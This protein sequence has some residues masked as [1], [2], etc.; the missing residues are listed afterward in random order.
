M[1]ASQVNHRVFA[2]DIIAEILKTNWI[3]ERVEATEL[4]AAPA[5]PGAN[6]AAGG[7]ETALKLL[8]M[9]VARGADRAPT[10]R[11][12]ALGALSALASAARD[13]EDEQEAKGSP[14]PPLSRALLRPH[15]TAEPPSSPDR[16]TPSAADARASSTPSGTSAAAP[17]S[18]DLRALLRRRMGDERAVVRRA[19]AQAT[20][21]VAALHLAHRGE[22]EDDGAAEAWADESSALGALCADVSVATRKAAAAGLSQLRALL[23]GSSALRQLWVTNVLP[24]AHDGEVTVSSRCGDLVREAIVEPASAWDGG[25]GSVWTL[26]ATAHSPEAQKCLQ[27]ALWPLALR[28]PDKPLSDPS[29]FAGGTQ[30]HARVLSSL[31]RAALLGCGRDSDGEPLGDGVLEGAPPRAEVRQGAWVLFEAVLCPS[32]HAGSTTAA[33]LLLTSSSVPVEPAFVMACWR[34]LWSEYDSVL[35]RAAAAGSDAVAPEQ[36]AAWS[37]E[38]DAL[39]VDAQRMLRAMAHLAPAIAAADASA[40]AAELLSLLQAFA[41]TPATAA[42]M[43]RAL[44]ALCSAKAPSPEQATAICNSFA[45]SLLDQAQGLLEAYAF[46]PGAGGMDED[47]LVA[48][49]APLAHV[50]RAL[51][52]VGEVTL[53]G[54]SPDDNGL[55]SDGR[56]ILDVHVSTELVSLV[57]VLLAHT[58]PRRGGAAAAAAATADET[59]S[60]TAAAA[61]EGPGEP[62]PESVRAFALVALGKICLVDAGLAKECV[63]LLVREIDHV[64]RLE[65]GV[66]AGS[67]AVQSN[68]LLVLGDLC[69]RYTALVERHMPALA[70]CLQ[71]PHALLRRHSLLLLSQLLLQDYLKWRGLLLPR[72]LLA[73]ADEDPEVSQLARFLVTGPLTQKSP[74]LLNHAP[75]DL[76]FVLNGYE[77]HPKYRACLLQGS[78]GHGHAAVDFRGVGAADQARRLEVHRFVCGA[79]TDEQRIEATARLAHEVLKPAAQGDFPCAHADAG[80]TASALKSSTK[81]GRKPSDAACGFAV[82]R[83]ALATLTLPELR[84]GRGSGQGADAVTEEEMVAAAANGHAAA[85]AAQ[86]LEAAKGRL[87]SKVSLLQWR[88]APTDARRV[89]PT[90]VVLAA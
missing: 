82:L 15:F 42:A 61:E 76:L 12:R 43:L 36:S 14:A 55:G 58:L 6:N 89:F 29:C 51:H 31:R 84:V 28:H 27:A 26:L 33:P 11:S 53:L 37:A 38:R 22:G 20:T 74:A 39:E 45:G 63:T 41:A 90:H 10:V 78:E 54:F 83:D 77:D 52:L 87:L 25:A 65:D 32:I 56:P 68:A 18:I 67:P 3:W 7:A 48:A 64:Q 35:E 72:F 71:S 2:V 59:P 73:C 62:V 85:A 60:G 79:L 69:V 57:R 75:V 81:A 66:P 24:L 17:R 49:A 1:V 80:A 21:A 19:A 50:E 34:D 9:L 16:K 88:C 70:R 44:V 4:A 23:P 5:T 46:G 40:L 13:L 8:G 86:G 30:L 47:A